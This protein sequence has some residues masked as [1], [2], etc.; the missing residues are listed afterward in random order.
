MK[1]LTELVIRLLSLP[2]NS[3]GKSYPWG[4]YRDPQLKIAITGVGFNSHTENMA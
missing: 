1:F 2:V 3:D 4:S